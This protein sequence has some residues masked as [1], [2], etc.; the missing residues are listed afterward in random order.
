M[1]QKINTQSFRSIRNDSHTILARL[2]R[3]FDIQPQYRNEEGQLRIV[4]EDSLK[5]ILELAGIPHSKLD[6]LSNGP[7]KLLREKKA[8]SWTRMVPDTMVVSEEHL[9]QG[10]TLSLPIA[11]STIH[12]VSLYWRVKPDSGEAVKGRFANSAMQCL[13]TRRIHGSSYVKLRLPFPSKLAIGYYLFQVEARTLAQSWTTA[14]R[15]IVTPNRCYVPPGYHQRGRFWGLTVQLY[16]IRSAGNWG[17]GD[18]RDLQEIIV[19]AGRDLGA[20]MVGVNPLHALLSDE[21]SPY[22]PSSRLFHNPLYLHIEDIA[23][24]SES[25]GAKRLIARSSFQRHLTFLRR[26]PIVQYEQ[27]MKLKFRVLEELYKTFV[28][29]HV[30]PKTQRGQAFLRFIRQQGT[31]L[32]Q[33]ACF[34]ALSET[35]TSTNSAGWQKWP[36][37]YRNPSSPIVQ[38]WCKK[39]LD[40]INYYRY[41]EWQCVKQLTRVQRTAER[42]GMPIGLYQDLAVGIDPRGADAWVY[43]DQLITGAMIGTPP[44]LFSPKGQNW[45]LCPLNPAELN[46]HGFEVFI[47]TFRALLRHGGLLRIDHAMGLFRMFWIPHHRSPA[48]GAY[49]KYPATALLGILALESYRAKT[50]LVGEDLGT[51]TPLIRRQLKES[52]LLSYRLLFFEKTKQGGFISPKKYPRQAMI[53]V[54]THDLPTLAGFWV[55]RDIEWKK[56]LDLFSDHSQ[57][58]SA[59][60]SR[61]NDKKALLRALKKEGLLPQGYDVNPDHIPKLTPDLAQAIHTFLART[62]SFLMAISLEDLLGLEETPNIPGVSQRDYPVWRL[63]T[64]GVK[65]TLTYWRRSK[66]VLTLAS[67][68]KRVRGFQTK[69]NIKRI[70]PPAKGVWRA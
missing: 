25:P 39:H 56:R 41:L 67:V 9:S 31:D 47:R 16:G 66:D 7:G 8:E 13:Q 52:G 60:I 17:I 2:A 27:V 55:G 50:C 69:E 43:Q 58:D 5:K 40:R 32:E 65:D 28:K 45:G 18:F 37:A 53:S 19:W 70:I 6:P 12:Q 36:E 33:F 1:S 35:L 24:F 30:L 59:R 48:Q 11:Q 4:P 20:A 62:P 14:C 54:T 15:L 21:M 38:Q 34:Q 68:L 51:I 57:V 22:S 10:W 44:E 42:I 64:G 23:D 61:E 46:R 29:K 49:V 63:K 3:R 26:S